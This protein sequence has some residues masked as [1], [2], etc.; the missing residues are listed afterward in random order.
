[1]NNQMFSVQKGFFMAFSRLQDWF[2]PAQSGSPY[3]TPQPKKTRK[4]KQTF[5]FFSKRLSIGV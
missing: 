4:T 3:E 1:M 2:D 5:P